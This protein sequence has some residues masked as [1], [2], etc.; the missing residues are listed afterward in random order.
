[1]WSPAIESAGAATPARIYD[2]RFLVV[3]VGG[4]YAS[5]DSASCADF[6][7]LNLVTISPFAILAGLICVRRE[8]VAGEVLVSRKVRDLVAGS[9]IEFADRGEH[10][11][12]GVPG[13]WQLFAVEDLP[14][15]FSPPR[16]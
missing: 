3:E 9:G 1:M 15:T 7:G 13:V 14:V 11:L 5:N 10:A 8:G 4:Y 6:C 2:L 16:G 12:K